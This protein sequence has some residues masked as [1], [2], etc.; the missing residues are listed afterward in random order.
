MVTVALSKSCSG[1]DDDDDDWTL[2]V[3]EEEEEDKGGRSDSVDARIVRM[4]WRRKNARE[5]PE[6][7][8]PRIVKCGGGIWAVAG[9][10]WGWIGERGK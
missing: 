7:P 3:A 1:D 5:R 9:V 2:A 6:T 8:P 10:G 4:R